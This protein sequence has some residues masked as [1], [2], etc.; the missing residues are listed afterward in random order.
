[1][2]SLQAATAAALLLAGLVLGVQTQQF[3]PL[4]LDFILN[5]D[6]ENGNF[7]VPPVV[8]TP[9]ELLIQEGKRIGVLSLNG[10]RHPTLQRAA[11]EH[12]N[13]QAKH[14]LQGHQML[15]YRMSELSQKLP[16]LK[17]IEVANESWDGQFVGDAIKEAYRSWKLSPGHWEAVNGECDIYG[18]AMC[19]GKNNVWYFCAIFAK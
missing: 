6:T 16:G 4:A 5:S 18:Y 2:R 9:N 13:F 19:L 17:F 8:L 12:A 15:Q 10:Q 1:M 3:A 7:I 14:G 11:E